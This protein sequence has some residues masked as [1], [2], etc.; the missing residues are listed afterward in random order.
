MTMSQ[1]E[2]APSMT[3]Q[4]RRAMSLVCTPVAVITAFDGFPHGTT[5]GAF[6]SLSHDPAMVLVSLK[7]DSDVLNLLSS[8]GTFGLN[9][10]SSTQANVAMRF[11]RKGRDSFEGLQ[12]EPES[13]SPRLSDVAVWA[14]CRVV[15]IVD[16][17]DHRIVMAEVTKVQ[18]SNRD[19]LT[20]HARA[21]GTHFSLDASDPQF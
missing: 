16:G 12:W 13:G 14:A 11:A 17:G 4:V 6:A 18:T 9:V 19:P 3:D 7:R 20:Y 1:V 10:L 8:T 15:S 2:V 21:F 5:V